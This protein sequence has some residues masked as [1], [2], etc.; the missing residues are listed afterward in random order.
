MSWT[1]KK[2]ATAFAALLFAILLTPAQAEPYLAF[3]TGNKCSACHVNPIGGGA[4][5][6]FGNYYGTHV[7]PALPGDT[8]GFDSG[9][10]TESVRV[11]ANLRANF[12]R[13]EEDSADATQ[14]FETQ[15]AQVYLHFQ[16]KG[17]RFS[18]YLDEQIA[19]GAALNREAFVMAK[20]SGNHYLKAGKIMLP[21]G[22]RLEDDSAFIRE[23]T[24]ITFDNSDNGVELGLDFDKALFNVVLSNGTGATNND[25][26]RFQ[27]VVRGEYVERKWRIGGSALVNE[28]TSGTRK[29]WGVFAGAHLYGFTLLAEVDQIVDESLIN[30]FGN[31]T[32]QIVTLFEVNRELGKGMNL[33]VTHE[34]FDPESN[35]D[36]NER[37][38]SSVLL[39]YT[40]F[41]NIQ[42]RGGIRNGDDIPQRDQGN[43]KDLFVQ[44]HLYF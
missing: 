16:P 34:T 7:L 10:L 36:N 18:F 22:I 25:D 23:A 43:F 24:Q 4:R 11:G 8:L 40:P 31:E 33:K 29:I 19:P 28:S 30:G 17:S 21:Y 35:T 6:T 14:G 1:F 12:Q 44:A 37:A 15:S 3:K 13:H 39:E 32:E 5:N 20:L 2:T 41:A 42:L 26:D 9:S 38:R 27:Y